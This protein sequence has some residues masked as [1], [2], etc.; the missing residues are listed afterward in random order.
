M[1]S[2]TMLK[3]LKIIWI[4]FIS[5]IIFSKVYLRIM[6]IQSL[7]GMLSVLLLFFL[8]FVVI[9]IK[10]VTWYL[11]LIVFLYGMYELLFVSIYAA[12]P[13]KMQFTYPLIYFLYGNY[14]R[15]FFTG[16]LNT[17]PLFFYSGVLIVLLL[18]P[19][20]KYYHVI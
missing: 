20:R 6:G 2:Q 16:A 13:T 7:G 5:I 8:I 9:Y 19:V 15:G 3:L 10:K 11:A 18:R 4:A 1:S 17:M 12:E 14:S